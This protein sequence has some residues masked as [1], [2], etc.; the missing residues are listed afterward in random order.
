MTTF[1]SMFVSVT[2]EAEV[3]DIIFFNFFTNNIKSCINKKIINA[4]RIYFYN[5]YF[6]ILFYMNL[7]LNLLFC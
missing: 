3:A 7:L 4:F 6:F 5:L 2:P 1:M